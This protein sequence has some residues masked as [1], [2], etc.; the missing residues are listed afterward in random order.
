MA[1]FLHGLR[2]Y[3]LTRDSEN[4]KDYTVKYIVGS[5]DPQFD[6]PE[7]VLNTPGLPLTGSTYS[8]GNDTNSKAY[9]R[10]ETTVSIHQE[11]EGDS[12][13][14][15]LVEKTFSTRPLKNCTEENF[16]DP[17]LEPQKVSGSF[18][19][20]TEEAVTDKDGNLLVSS[21]FEQFR[22]SKVE[23]DANRPTVKN[24]TECN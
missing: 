22:G 5:T 11:K 1:T 20:Y 24:R 3:G 19:K 7:A 13:P 16:D 2:S 23:F 17:L 10:P 15:W 21:S 12:H 6:T 9:C 18:V 8:I 14:W 4:Y